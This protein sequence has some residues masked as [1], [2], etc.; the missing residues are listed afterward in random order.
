MHVL[1]IAGVDIKLGL[2]Q[3]SILSLSLLDE[4]L[5]AV[6]PLHA[7]SLLHTLHPGVF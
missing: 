4:G 7:L 5:R 2:L 3:K 1:G 6:P